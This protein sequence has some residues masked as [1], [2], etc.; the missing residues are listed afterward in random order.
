M[1]RSGAMTPNEIRALE[2]LPPCENGDELL[3]SRDLIKL[4]NLDNLITTGQEVSSK[5]GEILEDDEE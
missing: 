3:V 5:N 4:S 2:D 1:M